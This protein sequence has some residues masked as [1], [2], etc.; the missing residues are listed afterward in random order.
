MRDINFLDEIIRITDFIKEQ[1]QQAHHENCLIGLSG[2]IDSALTAAL[3]VKAVGREK[4]RGVM[5]PYKS[6]QKESLD[7]ALEMAKLLGIKYEIIDIT[8]MVD[9]YFD[10]YQPE[11]NHL[12]R[13]NR[14]ARE[15]MC[16]LYDLS[17]RYRALVAGTSNRSELMVGY[18]TQYGDSACAFEPIAHLYKT[19]V[20]KM[21]EILAIPQAIIDK[22]PTADLWDNQTDEDELGIS[23]RKLDN[24]LYSL[25]EQCLPVN[26]IEKQ[27]FKNKDIMKVIKLVE[28]SEFKRKMPPTL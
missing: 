21:A 3:C 4:V 16:I 18:C 20:R 8:P 6:S 19:E 24:I 25:Y 22:N 13:G 1:L 23:Y 15:R 28:N 2:G 10:L 5:M 12:R 7:H 11:A 9:T 27:G 14:M 17:A 26:E